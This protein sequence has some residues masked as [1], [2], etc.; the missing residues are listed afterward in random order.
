MLFS[1]VAIALVITLFL[2]LFVANVVALVTVIVV[3]VLVTIVSL[4]IVFL[5]AA[6]LVRR[7]GRPCP[8]FVGREENS[9]V[10]R[11]E[12]GRLAVKS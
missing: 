12:E 5:V 11:R 7:P 1:L 4:A 3:V 2:V 9:V 10:F 8:T 6:F